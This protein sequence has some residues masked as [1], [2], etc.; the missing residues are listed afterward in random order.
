MEEITTSNPMALKTLFSQ[1]KLEGE[2]SSIILTDDSGLP[3]ISSGDD[4][5][6]D[7]NTAAT[8]SRIQQTILQTKDHLNMT[9]LEEVSLIDSNG[10]RLVIRPFTTKSGLMFL[11]VILPG[12]MISYK[13]IM[14]KVISK[15]SR[16]WII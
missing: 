15:I 11:A 7:D 5:E 8:V 10:K 16:E 12:K 13:R 2:F 1:Y 4:S 9:Q 6:D 14:K 3:I